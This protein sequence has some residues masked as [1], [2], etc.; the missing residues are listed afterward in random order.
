MSTGRS[1]YY[2][3]RQSFSTI[4]RRETFLN[5][6]QQRGDFAS[7]GG[8]LICTGDVFPYTVPSICRTV[9]YINISPATDANGA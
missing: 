3:W 7:A 6:G 4:N 2:Y 9:H 8:S 5:D 1:F